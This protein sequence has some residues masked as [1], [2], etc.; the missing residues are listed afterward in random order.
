MHDKEIVTVNL[1]AQVQAEYGQH[2]TVTQ[3]RRS[4]ELGAVQLH[5]RGFQQRLE[6]HATV[7]NV[8]LRERLPAW[9]TDPNIG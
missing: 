5:R 6:N 9:A 1:D 3:C 8:E 2:L 7:D 4:D